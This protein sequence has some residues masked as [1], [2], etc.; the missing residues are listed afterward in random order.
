MDSRN[1]RLVICGQLPFE[2]L[3]GVGSGLFDLEDDDL[4]VNRRWSGQ[5]TDMVVEKARS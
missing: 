5:I 3:G 4:L 1:R 2:R